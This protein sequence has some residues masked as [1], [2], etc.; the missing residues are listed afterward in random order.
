EDN[1]DGDRAGVGGIIA[2]ALENL[3]GSE[4]GFN[5]DRKTRFRQDNI[6]SRAGSIC[7]IIDSNTNVGLGQSR[8]VVDTI[9]SHGGEMTQFLKTGNNVVLMLR[10]NSSET[11][12][13]KTK[14]INSIRCDI[15]VRG[16]AITENRGVEHMITH[17]Q[18]TTG[19][20]C[21]GKL[22]SCDHLDLDTQGLGA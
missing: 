10:V 3:A 21:N 11:I 8:G 9:T 12:G 2:H 18:A 20:L 22:I 1:T 15:I 6:S 13:L 5:N 17:V 14:L 16:G 19:F 4:N 7:S